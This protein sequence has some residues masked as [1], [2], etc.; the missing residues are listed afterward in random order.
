M[1]TQLKPIKMLSLALVIG[2]CV[3]ASVSGA[4]RHY[5]IKAE[6]VQWD[7]MPSW[8]TNLMFGND[9]T[10]DIFT[11]PDYADGFKGRVYW[12]AVYRQYSKNFE[13]LIDGANAA[14]RGP[15]M[16]NEHL[17][18]VGPV[19]RAQV[20][21]TIIVHFKNETGIDTSI[22][23]HGVLYDK[24]GEGSPYLDGAGGPDGTVANDPNGP[25]DLVAPGETHIY[26]WE[27]PIRAGPGPADASSIVWLYHAHT[28]ETETTN[29][30]LIGPIV[31][32]RNGWAGRDGR[33]RDVDREFFTLFTVFNENV[34]VLFGKN[35]PDGEP[36]KADPDEFEESNL[37]HGL[38]GRLWGNNTG[39][40]MR[41]GQKV[42]WY[43]I[44]MGTE[45]DIHTSHWHGVTVLR[46]GHREDVTSIFPA[47]GATLELKTDNPGTWMY[48]CHVND[49]LDAGMMT[50]FTIE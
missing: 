46:N 7:Y 28:P 10:G 42:R 17:G 43:I 50:R 30:G 18:I 48:H 5:W 26:N 41:R 35:F 36:K 25:G 13:E 38:N 31:I 3:S 39:Y 44:A 29:A 4:V 21:D 47:E 24:T 12:K 6:E 40:T 11:D 37:M 2:L 32:T 27:V 20:G 1:R 33:P 15:G 19:I 16:P 14:T 49:H 9:L 23:P 34:S 45:V 22:H 8:P